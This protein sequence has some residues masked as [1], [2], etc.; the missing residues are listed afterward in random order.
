MAISIISIKD[1]SVSYER[2]RVLT[3]I[4]LELEAGHIYGVIGPN[5]AGKSTLFKALLGLIKVNTG[6]VLIDGK[7][8][9]EMRKS[10]VYVPQ[11]DEVDWQFPATV[12]D[13]VLQGRYPH[14]K[15]YQPLSKHDHNIAQGALEDLGIS[16]LSKRQIGELS[17]GQQQRVFLARALCQEADIFLLD[18]PFVGVDIT[19]E[20]RIMKILQSLAVQGKTILVIH[21][22]LSS[23]ERYFDHVIL[24]NQ[25]LIASG[26]TKT[27]FTTA[28]IDAAY[29]AQLPILHK[30]GLIE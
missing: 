20:D 4:F 24:L 15:I 2:K 5:G 29:R 21:H 1:L 9:E 26:E 23:V 10:L 19:T 27:T 3:N 22:D 11:K 7:P 12:M 25:R 28:N 14:K 8:V 17:G 13:V 16:H 18:E 6:L 30:T